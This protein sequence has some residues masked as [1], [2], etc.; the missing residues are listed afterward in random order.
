MRP[1]SVLAV[2]L[3]AVMAGG[4]AAAQSKNGKAAAPKATLSPSGDA[5]KGKQVYE[6]QCRICHFAA[7]REKKIGVGLKGIYP[8]GKY[9]DGK[10]VDDASMRE[11][12]LK[13]GKDMPGLEGSITKEQL[14][15]L[16]AYLKTL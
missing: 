13:G 16:I 10:K 1:G 3:L 15:D 5:K 2:F 7:S 4:L 11:W 14:E 12:I 8:R 9:E 6:E